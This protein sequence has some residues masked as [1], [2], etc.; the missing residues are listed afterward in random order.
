[1]KLLRYGAK[2]KEKP[3]ILDKNNQIR[4]LSFLITDIGG[5]VLLADNL[6]RIADIN[7]Q[8]L[9]VIKNDPRIGPCV[10][11][12]GKFLCIGLN[13]RDH[14]AET[15]AALPYEPVLFSKATSAI[16]GPNDNIIIP[17]GSKKTDWEVELGIIIGKP[18]KYIDEK[19]ALDYVAG[20][21]IVNDVSER[22]FQKE[23]TGQWIK[24]KSCDTFGP[25]GPYLV[26]KDEIPDPQ[27][28]DLWLEVDGHRYQQ[29]NTKNMIFGIAF[30]ISYLSR[31]FTL[32]PGDII[33]TGTPAGVGM[34]IKPTPIYLTAG[35]V[36][37]LGI[38]GLGEQTQKLVD[39]I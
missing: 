9:P 6:H 14:A 38:T 19:D 4:D 32:Y 20:Y 21:C 11:G 13:Y 33:A 35:Q 16:S 1:M 2:G 29:G 18:A 24:G 28:L 23:G 27:Q 39:D 26:T 10:A 25:I 5:D 17:R 15:G 31:F 22:A 36:V 12:V 34:G 8:D 3:G 37:H 7:L 30:L